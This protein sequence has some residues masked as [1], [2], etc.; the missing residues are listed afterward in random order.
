MDC[1]KAL[2]E[3]VIHMDCDK[4]LEEGVIYIWTMIRL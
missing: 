3:G 4:A 2:E 1:D